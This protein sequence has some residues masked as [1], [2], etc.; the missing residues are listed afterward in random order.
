VPKGYDPLVGIKTDPEIEEFLDNI[1]M[2]I[3][4]CVEVMPAHDEY[5]SK[6]CPAEPVV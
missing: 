1:A 2:T 4:R 5:V 3:R 6:F